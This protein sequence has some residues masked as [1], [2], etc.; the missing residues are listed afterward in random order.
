MGCFSWCLIDERKELMEGQ[1]FKMLI[2]LEFGG[3]SIQSTYD[4]YGNFTISNM[5]FDL[6]E[7]LAF[8][9]Q[10]QS[11]TVGEPVMFGVRSANEYLAEGVDLTTHNRNIGIDIGC[12]DKDAAKLKY[13]LR[14]VSPSFMGTYESLDGQFSIG[15]PNQGW[16]ATTVYDEARFLAET[17][18]SGEPLVFQDEDPDDE[19]DYDEDDED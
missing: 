1:P 7:I 2:P 12:Y 16:D 19:D 3:G 14:L 17:Y 13:P 4:D 18:Q 8:W 5:M 10:P 9:N 11:V 15:A 6:Y